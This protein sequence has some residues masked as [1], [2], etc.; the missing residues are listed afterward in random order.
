KNIQ[1]Q[2]WNILKSSIWNKNLLNKPKYAVLETI[3][4]EDPDFDNIDKLTTEIERNA[5][6]Q[7]EKIISYIKSIKNRF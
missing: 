2:Y 1:K 3:L 5:R 7:I 6:S 4:V